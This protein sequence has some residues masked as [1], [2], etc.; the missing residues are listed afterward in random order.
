MMV[1]GFNIRRTTYC[2]LRVCSGWPSLTDVTLSAVLR[3]CYY[4]PSLS[5]VSSHLPICHA[6][7]RTLSLCLGC[8]CMWTWRFS[9]L[10]GVSWWPVSC[11]MHSH[12]MH[13]CMQGTGEAER[14]L[15]R[16]GRW[17]WG[18]EDTNDGASHHRLSQRSK[19]SEKAE[20]D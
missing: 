3:C 12:A 15:T 4:Y 14:D 2:S 9:W 7:S 19:D 8:R 10:R 18:W 11:L 5:H 13:A 17:R 1:C 20:T 16:G 6:N